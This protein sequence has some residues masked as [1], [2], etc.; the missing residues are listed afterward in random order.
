MG[1]GKSKK[2][3][4]IFR[5]MIPELLKQTRNI[6]KSQDLIHQNECEIAAQVS[7]FSFND[8]DPVNTAASLVPQAFLTLVFKG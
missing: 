3:I 8:Q 1:A 7:W 2:K 6:S 4:G 5:N